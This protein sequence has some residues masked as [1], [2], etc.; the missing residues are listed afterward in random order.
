[1]N[2]LNTGTLVVFKI[3]SRPLVFFFLRVH[4]SKF[5]MNFS[6]LYATLVP[7][8]N[9]SSQFKALFFRLTEQFVL[10]LL[11]ECFP[12]I[13]LPSVLLIFL[14]VHY[15]SFILGTQKGTFWLDTRHS[16]FNNSWKCKLFLLNLA[17][18]KGRWIF[19]VKE[20]YFSSPP[21]SLY[22]CA[23]TRFKP[24]VSF[25]LPWLKYR[26]NGFCRLL[27]L[28]FAIKLSVNLPDRNLCTLRILISIYLTIWNLCIW[29]SVDK[30]HDK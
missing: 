7:H 23:I 27:Q 16:T 2:S 14:L 13:L 15:A 26:P 22:T 25:Q 5:C 3:H 1:M 9:H 28:S 24:R 12:V 8:P 10:I 18:N 29:K 20:F 6:F 21:S 17:C 4:K 11:R 19:P 30:S